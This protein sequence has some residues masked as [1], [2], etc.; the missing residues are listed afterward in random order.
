MQPAPQYEK[1]IFTKGL[2]LNYI[3]GRELVS[4]DSKAACQD[5]RKMKCVAISPTVY[6]EDKIVQVV[7][8]CQNANEAMVS[9]DVTTLILP[10]IKALHLTD[11]AKRF[12]DLTDQVGAQ[13]YESWVLLSVRLLITCYAKL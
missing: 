9:R 2:D 13:W 1:Y 12:K 6:S 7:D 4:S 11:G 5:L 8:L 10:P 3:K